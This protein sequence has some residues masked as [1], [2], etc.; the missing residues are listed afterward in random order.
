MVPQD[1]LQEERC[2]VQEIEEYLYV[3]EVL[4]ILEKC[5]GQ[6]H[7]NV[8]LLTMFSVILIHFVEE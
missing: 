1:K 5:I 8:M 7:K 3:L 2:H 6:L 4:T